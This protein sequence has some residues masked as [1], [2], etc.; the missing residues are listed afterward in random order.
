MSFLEARANVFFSINSCI[1]MRKTYA[2][3]SIILGF[4]KS[5]L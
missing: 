3:K 1:T 2:K 4:I 5:E